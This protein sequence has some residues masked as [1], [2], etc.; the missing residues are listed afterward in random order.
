M[1]GAAQTLE[2]FKAMGLSKKIEDALIAASTA[3]APDP[4]SF[5]AGH[6]TA[7]GQPR[8]TTGEVKVLGAPISSNV[9]GAVMI[10]MEA[11]V[12]GLELVD[13]MSGAH[14]AEPFL[15]INPYGQIPALVDGDLKLG[16][17]HAILRYLG[18]TYMPSLYPTGQT[19][20]CARIDMAMDAFADY[21]YK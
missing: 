19:K 5:V 15:A 21:V 3:N 1:V 6:L 18:A 4:V 7:G 17:S 16:E 10:A 20:A 13:V 11:G 14:K 9:I 2:R 12:G 8:G